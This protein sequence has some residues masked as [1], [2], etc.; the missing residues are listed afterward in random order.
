MLSFIKKLVR[1]TEK[2]ANPWIQVEENIRI[3]KLKIEEDKKNLSE[4]DPKS[5]EYEELSNEIM[6]HESACHEMTMKIFLL[7]RF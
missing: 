3:A 7:P 4:M 5:E 2:D 1:K 6:A